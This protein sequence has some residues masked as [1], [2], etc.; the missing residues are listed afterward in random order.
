MTPHLNRLIETVQMRGHNI[1]FYAELRK[2]IP[3]YRQILPLIQSSDCLYT[4]SYTISNFEQFWIKDI[5]QDFTKHLIIFSKTILK[6][7]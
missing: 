6:I 7:V 3:N 4:G 2:I 5:M 1:R